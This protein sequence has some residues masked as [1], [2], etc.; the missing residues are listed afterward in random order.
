MLDIHDLR[1]DFTL[2]TLDEK[3]LSDNPLIS[4]EQWFKE[5][6][7]AEVK[8]PSAMN[9]ATVDSFGKP[10]SRI[11]LLKEVRYDGFVFF[12]NYE[13]RKGKE[14]AGNSHC[15]LNFVWHELERQIRIEG[16][17]EK[18]SSEDSDKYFEVRPSKS[19]LGAWTSPQSEAIP[20]RAY[21]ETLYNDFDQ[22]FSG[23]EI[24]RPGNWGGYIVRPQLIEFWQGRSNRLHDRIQFRLEKGNWIKERLAP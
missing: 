14:L 4:F 23:K 22:Q 20:D 15:A 17:A 5:A 19:K 6:I 9:L 11:V 18:L 24:T 16:I 10:S 21:L 2:K 7:Q 3:E 12:T 13:S 1:R 8:E